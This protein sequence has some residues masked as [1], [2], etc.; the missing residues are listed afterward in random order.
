AYNSE[1]A[2]R[3]A[4][5][6]SRAAT[7]AVTADRHEFIGRGGHL[8]RPVAL[9]RETLS[10][11]AGAGLDPCAALQ[12]EVVLA[13]GAVREIVFTLGEGGDMNEVPSLATRYR[14][15]GAGERALEDVKREW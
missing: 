12:V 15:E 10:G 2:G 4:F 13:P 3:I 5:A 6:G 9:A 8:G 14:A 11:R 7:S 1:F